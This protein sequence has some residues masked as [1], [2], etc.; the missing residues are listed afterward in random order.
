MFRGGVN[1]ERLSGV[2]KWILNI[3]RFGIEKP[4]AKG[5]A[6]TKVSILR[7]RREYEDN[8]ELLKVYKITATI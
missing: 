6:R 5:S 3:V 8:K 1:T 4:L 2:Y 7:L